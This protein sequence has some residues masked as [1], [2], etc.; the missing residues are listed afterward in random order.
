M[1]FSN[2]KEWIIDICFNM[3]ELRKH[4]SEWDNR[5][6]KGHI[7]CV[8]PLRCWSVCYCG[9]IQPILNR[10]ILMI[11]QVWKSAVEIVNSKELGAKRSFR[12]GGS[13]ESL[14]RRIWA[15]P[16]KIRLGEERVIGHSLSQGT[17]DRERVTPIIVHLIFFSLKNELR[18]YNILEGQML[19]LLP[20]FIF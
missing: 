10:G 15:G 3:D 8:K 20:T 11:S 1:I 13:Q 9:I 19:Q 12:A 4:H 6:T 7:A 2:K 5:V 14:N 17:N 16:W 18:L